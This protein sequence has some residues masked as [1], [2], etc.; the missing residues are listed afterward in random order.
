MNDQTKAYA[1]IALRGLL[2]LVFVAAGGAKLAGDEHMVEVFETV[3]VGQW[4]RFVTGALEV[5][6]AILLFVPGKQALAAATLFCT[7]VGAT[8]AHLFL[9]GP[10]AIAPGVLGVLCAVV[11]S[12]YRSQLQSILG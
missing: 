1:L 11:V 4:F 9:L 12:A 6:M 5:S 10:G 7:M 8:L 2:A 3:G